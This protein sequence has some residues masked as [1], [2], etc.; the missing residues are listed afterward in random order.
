[1]RF[2]FEFLASASFFGFYFPEDG[3]LGVEADRLI[4]AGDSNQV[5]ESANRQRYVEMSPK[6]LIVC[7]GVI[8]TP[9]S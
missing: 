3:K 6:F 8:V 7:D 5:H 9:S 4:S 1:M 2:Y